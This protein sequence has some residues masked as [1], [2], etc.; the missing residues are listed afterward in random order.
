MSTVK[1]TVTNKAVENKPKGPSPTHPR[2]RIGKT[3]KDKANNAKAKNAQNRESRA[4][5][6]NDGSG[7]KGS[8][9]GFPY[10]SCNGKRNRYQVTGKD[11]Q[12][13]FLRD[14]K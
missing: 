4:S 8:K 2:S 12:T 9:M 11:N 3:R 7:G 1:E 13:V 6:Q 5:W 10:A 14:K